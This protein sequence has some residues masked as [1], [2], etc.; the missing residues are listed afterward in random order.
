MTRPEGSES[1]QP[2]PVF[3][4]KAGLLI[5]N[6]SVDT[7]PTS[8]CAG[9]NDFDKVWNELY[10]ASTT[11]GVPATN[12]KVGESNEVAAVKSVVIPLP[13]AVTIAWFTATVPEAS[14]NFTL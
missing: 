6:V 3:T 12:V 1:T 11:P 9:Q 5:V 14:T 7:W 2:I 8:T 13:L 4:V 10:F